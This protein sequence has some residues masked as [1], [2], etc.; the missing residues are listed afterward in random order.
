VIDASR[1]P[2]LR[3][4]WA[5]ALAVGF[6]LRVLPIQAARPYIAYVDEGNF[7]H[8][9][10]AM[11]RDGRWDPG[12]YLYPQLSRIAVAAAVRAYAPF[13]RTRHGGDLRRAL[14][15]APDVYDRLEPFALL[16]LARAI[17]VGLGILTVVLAGLLAARLAG[18][19]AGGA[20]VWLAAL[21]P[22]L[23]LRAPIAS[24]D[25]FATFF[26]TLCVYVAAGAARRSSALAWLLCGAS[27]GAAFASKYPAV[28]VA[29][30]PA[31]TILL[32]PGRWI[33]RLRRIVALGAGVAV[34]AAVA[35]PALLFRTRDVIGAIR[36]QGA[37]YGSFAT[38]APL[39]RQAFILAEW[40]LGYARP[41]LGIAFLLVAAAGLVLL[42]RN[43]STSPIAWGWAAWIA[44][45][46]LLYGSQAFQPFRNL[47][48]LV[49]ISCVAAASA[50][51]WI[52]ARLRRPLVFD[53]AALAALLALWGA[54]LAGYSWRRAHVADSRRL[55]VDWLA[56]RARPQGRVLVV[57]ELGMLDSE[58]RRVPGEA[59]ALW[60]RDIPAAVRDR[61]PDFILA[62]I[63]SR[64]DGSTDD[65]A[66]DPA[67]SGA[68][69]LRASFG[70]RPTPP[71]AGWWRGNDQLVRV[72]EKNR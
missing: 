19:A 67:I 31:V 51:V 62:G 60:W 22:A 33:E 13:Y 71:F 55:A 54:P 59:D 48:P 23:V 10:A 12:E 9:V 70:S 39:W 24:V 27:A 72:F 34:G 16:G 3:W 14:P 37:A 61:R 56:A 41:E 65:S 69:A 57:R 45:S 20:A 11:L 52:R 64:E 42:L 58:L 38:G 28:L 18:P 46:L 25:S 47:M 2:R 32:L 44:V 1:G 21:A 49:P 7:L 68:Y 53:A 5:A 15:S 6:A 66:A 17:D 26:A 50:Y 40:D 43:R 36:A 35:M 4:S 8:A 29:A 63:Q 30:A